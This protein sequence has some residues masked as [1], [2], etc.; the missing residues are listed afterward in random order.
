MTSNG[1][2][3]EE[4]DETVKLKCLDRHTRGPSTPKGFNVQNPKTKHASH[5][6]V[7]HQKGKVTSRQQG[8][9]NQGHCEETSPHEHILIQG[10]QCQT[11][12]SRFGFRFIQGISLR[13]LLEKQ[14]YES[15]CCIYIYHGKRQYLIDPIDPLVRERRKLPRDLV[16]PVND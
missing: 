7:R 14:V 15:E 9:H 16:T 3:S 12:L 8:P 11:L 5:G 1:S 13:V 10:L 2:Q 4:K 6:T